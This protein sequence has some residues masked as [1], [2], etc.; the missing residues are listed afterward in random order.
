M[1]YRMVQCFNMNIS[2]YMLT[3]IRISGDT[4][5]DDINGEQAKKRAAHIGQLSLIILI[6]H[7][8]E[9]GQLLH[10]REDGREKLSQ[11][12][13]Q[14]GGSFICGLAPHFG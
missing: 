7:S 6:F 10:L 13:R 2:V 4:F 14:M 9:H 1:I 12:E 11:T 5:L 8:L 3:K